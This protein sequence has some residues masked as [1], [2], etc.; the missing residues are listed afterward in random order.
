MDVWSVY[1]VLDV[2]KE[3]DPREVQLAEAIAALEGGP[4]QVWLA[5]ESS[6][7]DKRD[8][9]GDEAAQRTLA[10]VLEVADRHGVE[11]A[12]YPHFGSWMER[13]E[14]VQ[15]LL[16]QIPHPH[17]GL[18]FNVCHWFRNH[19]DA[20]PAQV[21]AAARARLLAV[22]INGVTCAGT[23]WS[24]LIRPLDEGDHDLAGFL[25]LL[26]QLRFDGPV[27]LQGYGLRQAPADHLARSQAVWRGITDR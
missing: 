26:E 27:G 4:G 2:A 25:A 15:R 24:S 13:V 14:D 12:L 3:P 9:A 8:P 18:C 22:T 1:A 11:V 10:R 17:L 7:H 21:L 23:G 5:L 19:G 16:D 6:A 20:D